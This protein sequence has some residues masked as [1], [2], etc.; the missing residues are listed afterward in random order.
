MAYA[1]GWKFYIIKQ[2]VNRVGKEIR[3]PAIL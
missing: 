2:F 1:A 3:H